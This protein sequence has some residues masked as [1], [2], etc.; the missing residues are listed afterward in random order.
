MTTRFYRKR[1]A[2]TLLEVDLVGTKCQNLGDEN[3]FDL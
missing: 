2:V 3:G 1:R